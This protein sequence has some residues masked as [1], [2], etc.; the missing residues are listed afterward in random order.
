MTTIIGYTDS[1]TECECCGKIDLKG[2]YCLDINGEELY[3]GSVCA[4]KSHGLTKDEQKGMKSTFTK[5]QKNAKLI[6]MHITPLMNELQSKL[7]ERVE[8]NNDK[9]IQE[10]NRAINFR[11][12]KYKI[13]LPN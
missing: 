13:T 6:E 4:F 7:S 12:A 10:Y 11:A 3:Y 2:T 5:Y 8:L 9:L 1:I